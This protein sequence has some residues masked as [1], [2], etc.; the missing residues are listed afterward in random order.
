MSNETCKHGYY[1]LCPH[2]YNSLTSERDL[3]A[4]ELAEL[5]AQEPVAWRYQ[6]A[7]GNYRYRGYVAGFDTDYRSLKP[8]PL[9]AAPVP[10]AVK[11]SLTTAAHAAVPADVARDA[12]VGAAIERA[13]GSLP[14]GYSIEIEIENGA[15][16]VRLY[17]DEVCRLGYDGDGDTLA[18]EINTATD[19]A[20]AVS[21]KK[22]GKP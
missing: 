3:L 22:E 14:R 5:R 9:Y 19:T 15:A 16:T 10:A 2:C 4:K 12:A 20:R 6:E 1:G 21:Q 11:D 13:A 18:G 8:I 7:N 17:D